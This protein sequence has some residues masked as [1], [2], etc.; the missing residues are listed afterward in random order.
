MSISPAPEIFEGNN[1]GSIYVREEG[2]PRKKQAE[3]QSKFINIKTVFFDHFSAIL[4]V[5]G[6]TKLDSIVC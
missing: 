4:V 5:K 3:C 2:V 6:E 1:D